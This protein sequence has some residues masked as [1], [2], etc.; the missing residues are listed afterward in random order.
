[1]LLCG[2]GQATAAPPPDA[3]KAEASFL[4]ENRDAM[5]RM[6]SGMNVK[7][8]GDVDVDFVAMM[9]PH[10]QGAIDMARSVLRYG[11]NEQIRRLAQ[12]IIVEQQ[13]EIAAMRL[14]LGPPLRPSAPAPDQ[15]TAAVSPA[16]SSA[17]PHHH[18]KER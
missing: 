12:E 13:Q 8:T 14:A 17:V 5:N 18:A 6:M 16:P 1:M 3:K 10:H 2:P 15:P 11:K 7:P 9:V 4:A